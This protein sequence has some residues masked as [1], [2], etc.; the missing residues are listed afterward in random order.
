MY[1]T[2][3]CPYCRQAR[4]YFRDNGIPFVEYD[5]EKD[6]AA[7]RRYDALGGRGVPVILVGDCRMNYMQHVLGNEQMLRWYRQSADESEVIRDSET[8]T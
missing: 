2:S 6:A 8:G 1:T 4:E 3:W 5:I 7:R